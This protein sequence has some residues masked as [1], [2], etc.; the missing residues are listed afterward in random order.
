MI[1]DTIFCLLSKNC[2]WQDVTEIKQLRKWWSLLSIISSF[3]LAMD[4]CI[5]VLIRIEFIVETCS[6]L[7]TVVNRLQYKLLI[8]PFIKKLNSLDC[9]IYQHVLRCWI[10]FGKEKFSFF[11]KM[12]KCC[13]INC[14]RTLVSEL[15]YWN[16][17]EVWR[18]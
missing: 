16:T 10:L 7:E 3:S 18:G 5:F 12:R 13:S 14:I 17:L 15:M 2:Q 6:M 8:L 4:G 1:G 11:L 9:R